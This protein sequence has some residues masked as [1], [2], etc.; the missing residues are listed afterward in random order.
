MSDSFEDSPEKVEAHIERMKK[1][2]DALLIE[3]RKAERRLAINRDVVRDHGFSST[4][5]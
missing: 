1:E 2:L 3:G 5:T 4:Y